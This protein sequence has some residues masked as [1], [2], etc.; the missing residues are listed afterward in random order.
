MFAKKKIASLESE[1]N[2]LKELVIFQMKDIKE[3]KIEIEKMKTE[4]K[5]DDDDKPTFAQI[6][7]EWLNGK[8]A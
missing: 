5:A 1:V 6:V 2:R 8:E 4:T 3:M 7:D